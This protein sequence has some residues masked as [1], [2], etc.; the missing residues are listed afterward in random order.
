MT[1]RWTDNQTDR[2]TF[3]FLPRAPWGG[4]NNCCYTPLHV[5]NSHTKF[6]WISANGLEGDSVTVGR[7]EGGNCNIPIAFFKKRGNNNTLFY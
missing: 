6:G 3:L 7:M 2:Q 5:S 1:D 4:K